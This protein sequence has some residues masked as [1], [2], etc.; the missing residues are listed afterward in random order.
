MT[1]APSR[2]SYPPTASVRSIPNFIVFGEMGVGKSSLINLIA[3]EQV[4]K[5][6]PDALSCTL[7]STEHQIRV[8]DPQLNVNLF[9]TAGLD[10]PTVDSHTGYLNA[11]V[12]A[13]ELIVS[14][15]NQGG[16]HGLLFCVK[17]RVTTT[18]QQNYRLIFEFLCQG[19]VPLALVVTNL[20]NEEESM[21]EWWTR[22][23][24]HFKAYGIDPVT[25]VCITTIKGHNNAYATRYSESRTKVHNILR[26]LGSR[27][28]CLVDVIGWFSWLCKKL[29]LL[30][31][32]ALRLK[33]DH[34]NT[35]RML[36]KRCKLK[37]EHAAQLL[38]NIG[39]PS[40]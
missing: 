37:E 33:L 19:Q 26:E 12:K 3:G 25:H 40:S 34:W 32:E 16:V 1:R 10:T 18:T 23:Q 35:M 30:V 7:G 39:L 8:S 15:K 11:L 38:Q 13:H 9:D 22:N 36:T 4:A 27:E 31:P 29:W 28:A 24:A 14:L 5:V 6:S 21:D 2:A 17:G 20:E